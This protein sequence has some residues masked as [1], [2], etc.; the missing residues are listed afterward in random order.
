MIDRPFTT[1]AHRSI[2]VR[3]AKTLFHVSGR[4]AGARASAPSCVHNDHVALRRG[5]NVSGRV[6]MVPLGSNSTGRCALC[7]I[8]HSIRFA[9][10]RWRAAA[11]IHCVCRQPGL[12]ERRDPQYIGARADWPRR[13]FIGRASFWASSRDVESRRLTATG[14]D[15]SFIPAAALHADVRCGS[16]PDTCWH[17]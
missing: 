1:A 7:R 13:L 16:S 4:F 9:A 17:R 5:R 11:E 3:L 15:Q 12:A 8:S 2:L 10:G 14:V 6:K